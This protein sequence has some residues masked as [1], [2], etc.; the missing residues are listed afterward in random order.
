MLTNDKQLLKYLMELER[1]LIIL[2]N[3]LSNFCLYIPYGLYTLD[4]FAHDIEIL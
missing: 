3:Y 4:I 1:C 2:E